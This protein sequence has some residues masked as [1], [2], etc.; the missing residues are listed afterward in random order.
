LDMSPNKFTSKIPS[1]FG[2]LLGLSFLNLE[3]NMLEA[4]DSTGWELFADLTTCNSL[5]VLSLDGNNLRGAIPNFISNLST[6][7]TNLLM[8]DNQLSEVVPSSIGKFNGLIE[9]ALDGNNFTDTIEDWI[10]K[11]TPTRVISQ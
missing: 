9:L 6:N 1:I 7:L 10:P 2:K 3:R 8:S 11:L 5:M 4:S